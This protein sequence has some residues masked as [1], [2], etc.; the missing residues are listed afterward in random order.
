LTD[1]NGATIRPAGPGM[2]IGPY[3]VVAT[4]SHDDALARTRDGGDV[5]LATG[6]VDSIV[7]EVRS[8]AALEGRAATAHVLERGQDE[9][10][11]G[12]IALTP[13]PPD[14]IPFA[15]WLEGSRPT[16]TFALLDALLD[17]A[18]TLEEA[19]LD[20]CPRVEDLWVRP[21]PDD[22]PSLW[23]QRARGGAQLHG[24]ERVDARAI[25]EELGPTLAY[26]AIGATPPALLHAVLPCRESASRG[27]TIEAVRRDL[28][29]ARATIGAPNPARARCAGLSDVGLLRERNEDAVAIAHERDRAV[30]VV[31]DGISASY[32]A[33]L[34]ARIAATTIAE[35]LATADARGMAESVAHAIRAA[36]LAICAE[37][38]GLGGE[39]LGTTAVAA[40]RVGSRLAVGWV[41][42]SRA[43]WIDANGPSRLLTRDH[44]WLNDVLATGLASMEEALQSPY[45][46]ALTRCLGPLEGGDPSTQAEPDA[47]EVEITGP[48]MLILCSDGL[49]N[50]YPSADDLA[51]LCSLAGS[52]P[53]AE[54]LARALENGA[55]AR[56][57]QD[58]VTVAVLL[59]E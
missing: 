47:I 59:V 6:D 19:A 58:N 53:T 49:W 51:S 7:R 35:Q 8:L 21:G 42:D 33:D 20:F 30:L 28:A 50:Y 9:L 13:P 26:R 41:G 48:G 55:L 16:V 2:A 57:G 32:R 52:S 24:G 10:A 44:S 25:L 40:L 36:H 1:V 46:H 17:V 27:T 15:T 18:T 29:R 45:A 31:C 11:G 5:V 12:W 22:R 23:L 34:A 56:G 43:Y 14:A 38:Q 3:T 54:S 4:R 39:P 37:H